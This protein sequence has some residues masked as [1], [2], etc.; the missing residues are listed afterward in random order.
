M[1]LRAIVLEKDGLHS[2]LNIRDIASGT[3]KQRF[4][5]FLDAA[6]AQF[7]KDELARLGPIEARF[8]QLDLIR[9]NIVHGRWTKTGTSTIGFLLFDRGSM[10]Q[11]TIPKIYEIE[12]AE[13][14]NLVGE[15]LS[16]AVFVASKSGTAA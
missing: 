16:I 11:E 14:E 2:E 5:L 13:F 3:L 6:N 12:T 8:L 15:V 7:S 1:W 10:R 9:N 4:N